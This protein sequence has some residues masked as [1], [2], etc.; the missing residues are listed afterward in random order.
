MLDDEIVA[1]DADM[2]AAVANSLLEE[3]GLGPDSKVDENLA[4]EFARSGH[5]ELHNISSMTGGVV[6]Q[7]A[8]KLITHQYV[9]ENSLCI[10]DGV[11]AKAYV[12]KV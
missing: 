5:C 10:I 4:L 6:S 12:A 9:P 1:R 11:K 3:W 2:L 8:I 7:E